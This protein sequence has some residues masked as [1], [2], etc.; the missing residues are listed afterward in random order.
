MRA[1]FSFMDLGG[2]GA[3]RSQRAELL[4]ERGTEAVLVAVNRV[5]RLNDQGIPP[6]SAGKITY[7]D[8]KRGVY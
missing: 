2:L 7:P 3:A 5:R 1:P 6:P 4:P 8:G